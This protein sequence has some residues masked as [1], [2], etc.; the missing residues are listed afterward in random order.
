MRNFEE[1]RL[2]GINL[3]GRG[4]KF[5]TYKIPRW[6]MITAGEFI[7]S[8]GQRGTRTLTTEAATF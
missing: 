6:L 1:K 7:V 8:Y 2:N 5:D 3:Y 4:H